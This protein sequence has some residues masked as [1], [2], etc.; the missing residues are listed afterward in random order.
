MKNIQNTELVIPHSHPPLRQSIEYVWVWLLSDLRFSF[1]GMKN[2]FI[3]EDP[4]AASRCR[5]EIKALF[6]DDLDIINV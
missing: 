5:S 6:L 4:H 3:V 2:S 1:E